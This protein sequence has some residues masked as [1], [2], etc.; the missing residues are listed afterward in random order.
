M[1]II[2]FRFSTVIILMIVSFVES[3]FVEDSENFKIRDGDPGWPPA[4]DKKI[5]SW[6]NTPHWMKLSDWTDFRDN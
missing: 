3:S 1:P 4:L 5:E 6:K 2:T